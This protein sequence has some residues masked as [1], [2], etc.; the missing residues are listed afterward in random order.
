MKDKRRSTITNDVLKCGGRWEA[1]IEE[2]TQDSAKYVV[3]PWLS[4]VVLDYFLVC[5]DGATLFDRTHV[6]RIRICLLLALSGAQF[7]DLRCH[8][9]RLPCK[10]VGRCLNLGRDL[11]V[12]PLTWRKLC[13]EAYIMEVSVTSSAYL[14]ASTAPGLFFCHLSGRSGNTYFR[15]QQMCLVESPCEGFWSHTLIYCDFVRR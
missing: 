14:L 12:N 9:K 15:G 11:S 3:M 7:V 10:S 6:F 8:F 2:V 5:T 4:R 13:V 1:S